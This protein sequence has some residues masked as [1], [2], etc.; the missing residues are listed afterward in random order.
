L[1]GDKN[2]PEKEK[3]DTL[4]EMEPLFAA[5]A[6]GCA[7]GL[8]QEALI[9]DVLA[10]DQ[11]RRGAYTFHKLGAFGADLAALSH[12]FQVPWSQPATGLTEEDKA[13]VLSFKKRDI[14]KGTGKFQP[15]KIKVLSRPQAQGQFLHLNCHG[16][17]KVI[18][19]IRFYVEFF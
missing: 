4:A 1:T 11:E 6:H 9:D 3:P 19:I 15:K 7:A 8:H 14:K 13:L 12:F 18:K 16:D 5:V 2:L 17:I 10:A